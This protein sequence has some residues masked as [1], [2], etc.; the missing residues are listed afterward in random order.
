MSLGDIN[1][2]RAAEVWVLSRRQFAKKPSLQSLLLPEGEI[3]ASL[4]AQSPLEHGSYVKLDPA[5]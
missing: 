5:G 3:L 1:K 4:S 2:Y